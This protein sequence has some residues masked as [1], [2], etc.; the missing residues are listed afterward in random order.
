MSNAHVDVLIAGAGAAGLAAALSG[1]E[2]GLGVVVVEANP[3]FRSSSNT[4]MSTSM[5]PAGGSRWQTEAGID[6]SPSQ[7]YDDIMAKTK[8]SADPVVTR[9]LTSVAPEL[10]RWMADDVGVPFDLVTEFRYPGHSVDRCLAVPDRS[11]RTLH[12]HL[13][14][15]VTENPK[16]T[17]MNPM[18][19]TSVE[20]DVSNGIQ[21]RVQG[22]DSPSEI[23]TARSVVLATN[24]FAA[25]KEMVSRHLPEIESALY[26]GGDGSTGD[27][28][29]IG[30]A[31]GADVA[32]MDSYQ[33]H[34]SVATPHGVIMTWAA[35]M[36]GAVLLNS[37]GERFGDETSG[38]S[39]YA[40]PVLGQ[41]GGVA[42]VVLDRRIDEACSVF[43]DYQDLSDAGG[44]RW[45]DDVEALAST[46][47]APADVV[48]QSLE[49]VRLVAE[50]TG[51]DAFGRVFDGEILRPP[52]GSVKVTG[53]L[54]HTQGGLR[55]D[56]NARVLAGGKP[57]QGLYAAGGAAAGI[58]GHGASG[59][60]AGN[61]LLS[62]LGLGY[63]AGRDAGGSDA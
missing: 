15:A 12:R 27:A 6:D 3:S 58:S 2:R 60:L 11:G 35:V 61:G 5:V 40:V 57:I 24:G 28:L 33:G 8:E 51:V 7:F 29:E 47:G 18:R 46:I 45:S 34:G 20:T 53:A 37:H 22:P 38:Y 59:Y 26:H 1:A 14:A 62:A 41:P 36:Q 54:F 50:G 49:D 16:I 17:L 39:E 63:L 43:K 13:L 30:E 48:G 9:A 4:A 32:F 10:V 21:C 42:W 56:G 19:L 31:L 23:V 52:Y 25:R 44:V 55:V